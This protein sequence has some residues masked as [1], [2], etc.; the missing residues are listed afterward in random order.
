[1]RK[2]VCSILA[3]A[4]A[5]GA[6]PLVAQDYGP[7]TIW[8]EAPE[9][10]RASAANAAL[11]DGSGRVVAEVP[12]GAGGLFAFRDVA[13]G[14]YIVVLKDGAGSPLVQS[15]PIS[16]ATGATDKAIFDA[17]RKPAAAALKGG[18]LSKT[19]WILIGAG[20]VGITT[21]VII[22]NSGNEET[23]ASPSR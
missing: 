17:S 9:R 14:Q 22:A 15:F 18:G 12:V 13:P 8:G 3:V 7:N 19:A 23:P 21:A 10:V 1:M 20:A 4:L 16:F 5:L 2:A 11:Q 6:V